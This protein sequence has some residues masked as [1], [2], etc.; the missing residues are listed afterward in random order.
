MNIL[1]IC[2]R[3]QWRS[4]TAEDIY[5]DSIHN[6]RSAGTAASA[7]IKVNAK[8]IDWSDMIFVMEKK[9]KTHVQDKFSGLLDEKTII[10]L[11]I[12]DEYQ[13][14]DPE[15]IEILALSVSPYID[16]EI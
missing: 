8:L 14:M 4:R 5:K 15:L 10:I 2:S 13:Y 9:H 1:F 7:K 6:V 3:N 11:D 12:A 16:F